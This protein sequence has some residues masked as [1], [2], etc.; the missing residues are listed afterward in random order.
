MEEK[1]SCLVKQSDVEVPES[2]HGE[3]FSHQIYERGTELYLIARDGHRIREETKDPERSR[4]SSQ[5]VIICLQSGTLL[6]KS[7]IFEHGLM[8]TGGI[9]PKLRHAGG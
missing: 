9:Y 6:W 4:G 1:R 7:E 5:L 8:L 2:I 3:L